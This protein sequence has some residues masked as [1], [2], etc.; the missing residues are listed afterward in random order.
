MIP[1]IFPLYLPTRARHKLL[2]HLQNIL[3]VACYDFGKRTLP[4]VLQQ[5][6]WDCAEAVELNRWTDVLNKRQD[7]FAQVESIKKPLRDLFISIAN[8]RHTAV[9]RIQVNVKGIEQFFLDAETLAVIMEETECAEKIAKL[10]RETQVVIE[11][12]QRNKILLHSKLDETLRGLASQREKLKRLEEMAI[13]EMG[14]EDDEYQALAG[15]SIEEIIEP[16]EASFL[17]AIE[18]EQETVLGIDTDGTEEDDD[19]LGSPDEA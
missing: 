18:T 17:T 14:N 19:D 13:I 4:E 11:E 3:E 9:H 12:L 5:R 6:D 2:V 8:I 10:R 15:K 1:P 16:S 7:V